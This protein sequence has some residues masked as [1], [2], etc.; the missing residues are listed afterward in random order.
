[1]EPG[2]SRHRVE[3]ADASDHFRE[4]FPHSLY[5]GAGEFHCAPAPRDP[6]EAAGLPRREPLGAQAE[7][8][9]AMVWRGAR[10]AGEIYQAGAINAVLLRKQEPIAPNDVASDPGLL[11]S[12]EH[13]RGDARGD[14]G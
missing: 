2:Q 4:G 6:V 1:M 10:V 9:D 13:G 11:L 5:P 14:A 3:D 7:E 8:L 12:Q